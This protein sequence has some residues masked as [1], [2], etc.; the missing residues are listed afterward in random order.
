MACWRRPPL[1]PQKIPIG[2][3]WG[4]YR[5]LSVSCLPTPVDTWVHHVSMKSQKCVLVTATNKASSSQVP[6]PYCEIA[7]RID[8]HDFL[9]TAWVTLLVVKVRLQYIRCTARDSFFMTYTAHW[10]R[11]ISDKGFPK[12]ACMHSAQILVGQDWWAEPVS[13]R[14]SRSPVS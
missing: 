1:R 7:C 6:G 13:V 5:F 8:H 2:G 9:V 11:W 3:G 14:N 10:A 4:S 12:A